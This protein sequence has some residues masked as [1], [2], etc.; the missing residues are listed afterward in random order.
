MNQN[1]YSRN[2]LLNE[3]KDYILN[4]DIK[5]ILSMMKKKKKNKEKKE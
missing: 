3:S 4:L 5:K 2:K 1:I